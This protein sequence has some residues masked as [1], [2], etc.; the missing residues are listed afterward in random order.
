MAAQQTILGIDPGLSGAFAIYD[1]ED[2]GVADI[3]TVKAA[4][5]GREVDWAAL[6]RVLE[7]TLS[8]SDPGHAFIERVGAM[9]GQGVSSMFKFGFVA[10]GLR[11]LLAAYSMPV[12]YVTPVTWKRALG[13]QKGK[14]AARARASELIPKG[15]QYWQRVKDDGR[16]EAALIA[17]YGWRQLFGSRLATEAA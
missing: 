16:A 14:D 4:S 9:P 17:L 13:V 8:H 10:G 6:K 11:G 3:P 1:G 15:A 5:R 7:A 12:T 2:I